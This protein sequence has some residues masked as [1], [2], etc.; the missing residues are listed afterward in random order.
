MSALPVYFTITLFAMFISAAA[1]SLTVSIIR[2]SGHDHLVRTAML[3]ALVVSYF[4]APLVFGLEYEDAYVHQAAARYL[5]ARPSPAADGFFETLCAVGSLRQCAIEVTYGT[6]L[7]GFAAILYPL[8]SAFP[9]FP[10]LASTASFVL[11][12]LMLQ[13]FWSALRLDTGFAAR[14]LG[15]GMLASAPAFYLICGTGFAEPAYALFLATFALYAVRT[16][17]RRLTAL[18]P[19]EWVVMACA[20]FLAVLVKKEALLILAATAAAGGP[21]WLLARRRQAPDARALAALFFVSVLAAAFAVIAAKVFDA[22]QRHSSDIGAPSFALSYAAELL[23]VIATA[24]L[25]VTRYG[26][27]YIA[28]GLLLPI[29]L[30]RRN[31]PAL[32]LCAITGGYL[33]LYAAHARHGSF[34]H[35]ANVAP[36][37]MIRYLYPLAPLAAASCAFVLSGIITRSASLSRRLGLAAATS[38]VLAAAAGLHQGK[39]QREAMAADEARRAADHTTLTP[40]AHSLRPVIVTP[41][42]ATIYA[43]SPLDTVVIDSAFTDSKEARALVGGSVQNP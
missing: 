11:T 4:T 35:G 14:L 3:A 31:L 28:A 38:A 37:E 9:E 42:S 8:A 33:L 30:S 19:A 10:A 40:L 25:D 5:A 23:P 17:S 24:G 22:A 41:Y 32:C 26:V 18:S 2:E 12:A 36:A 7:V 20:A 27:V 21:A 15:L 6:Q 43:P 29:A 1:C 39:I 16:L 34:V 13:L